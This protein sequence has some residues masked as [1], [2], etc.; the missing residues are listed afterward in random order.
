MAGN[1]H[2]DKYHITFADKRTT[3]SLDT[4]L[5]ELLAIKL[6]QIPETE[7]AH[8][9]VRGWLQKTLI[10]RM[11]DQSAPGMAS[12]FARRYMLEFIA[13]KRLIGKWHDWQGG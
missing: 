5:S 4:M 2:S 12:H 6:N 11:G 1:K 10:E 7:E 8:V 13:D 9:A 3:I